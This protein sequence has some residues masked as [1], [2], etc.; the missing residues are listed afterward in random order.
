MS[1][2]GQELIAFKTGEQDGIF[3]RA[4]DNPYNIAVVP[5]SHRA[6]EEGYDEGTGST[7]PPRGPAGPAGPAGAQGSQGVAGISGQDG[8]DGLAFL[9]GT[10]VPASG[11]GVPGDTYL[12]VATNIVYNK[13]G[14][15]TWT[16]TGRLDD[17][18]FATQLDDTGG[19]PN[20]IYKGEATA[21]ELLSAAT[22]RIQQITVTTDGGG[23]D[24]IGI[25]WADGDTDFNNVWD[26]RLGLSYA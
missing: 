11:L 23:N 21:G 12:D 7:I 8:A 13:T 10:G 16:V 22:W 17:V 3:G 9:Q 18:T 6:Y 24:D 15:S 1:W 14:I 2:A 20:I 19:A 26:D 25:L 4:R 5:R